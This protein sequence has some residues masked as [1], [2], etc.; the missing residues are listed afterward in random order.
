MILSYA[1]WAQQGNVGLP[2]LS[3]FD[4]NDYEY[5]KENEALVQDENGI[6]YIANNDGLLLFD[7]VN[8]T[9]MP[10]PNKSRVRS[11][12]LSEDG[13]IYL[14]GQGEFGFLKADSLFKMTY[15]SLSDSIQKEDQLPGDIWEIWPFENKILF[16]AGNQVLIYDG[17]TIKTFKSD[18]FFRKGFLI[19]DKMYIQEDGVGLYYWNGNTLVLTNSNP[20]FSQ[21]GVAFLYEEDDG[22][23]LIGM[24]RSG[25]YKGDLKNLEKVPTYLDNTSLQIKLNCGK[26]LKNGSL[27]LGTVNQGLIALDE[28][29]RLLYELNKKFGLDVLTIHDIVE[30]LAG[31][32]WLTSDNGLILLDVNSPLKKIDDRLGVFGAGFTS[33]KASNGKVLFG[34]SQAIFEQKGNHFEVINNTEGTAWY[35]NNIGTNTWIGTQ[36]GPVLYQYDELTRY[37]TPLGAWDFVAGPTEDIVLAG[38]YRGIHVFENKG[39]KWEP[40]NQIEGI[41]ES[42]RGL[43]KENDSVLW[44]S[45]PYKGVYR[46]QLTN[47]LT[48]AKSVKAFGKKDG[49]PSDLRIEVF[50]IKEQLLFTSENGVFEFD[51]ENERFRNCE[52]F[53]KIVGK[54]SSISIIQEDSHGYIWFVDKG[55]PAYIVDEQLKDPRIVKAPLLQ[56]KDE[57]IGSYEH[58]NDLG[59]QMIIGVQSGYVVF[60]YLVEQ[61]D[62]Y[63]YPVTI[64]RVEQTGSD[65]AIVFDGFGDRA[66]TDVFPYEK[67]GLKFHYSGAD[68]N[69]IGKMTYRYKLE[70]FDEGWSEW[71]KEY[72][73]EYTNLFEGSYIFQ[74][75]AKNIYGK[76]ILSNTWGFEILPPWYRTNWAYFTFLIAISVSLYGSVKMYTHYQVRDLKDLQVKSSR[77]VI[78]LKNEKLESEAQHNTKQLASMAFSLS[79]KENAIVSIKKELEEALDDPDKM[80]FKIK[81]IVSHIN[82]EIDVQEEWDVFERHFD[83][84]HNNFMTRLRSKHP[85]LSPIQ[86]KLSAYLRMNLSSKE[87]ADLMNVSV[88]GVEKNRYRLRKKLGLSQDDNLKAYIFQ[89]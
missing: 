47:D 58:F 2:Y 3:H 74:V 66:Q 80:G 63:D 28:N 13:T 30:D 79:Q 61:R 50:K 89:I 9:L 87:M 64:R 36:Y 40:K 25:L 15:V 49:L 82:Q 48:K 68:Y 8:W 27:L 44:M 86:N 73:K 84:V 22:A 31:Q 46:L 67:N 38:N 85:D 11:L 75:E 60:D 77:E 70:G 23:L 83:Q 69:S 20:I 29:G 72:S 53:E 37:N 14:G 81:K 78:R 45:Q 39:G 32:M 56:L 65:G 21:E 19:D 33:A 6:L 26:K 16:L 76:S 88:S 1:G 7:G 57:L 51:E 43:V 59:D 52:W 4:K 12:A 62:N 41:N 35:M 42:T 34:T 17:C 5:G 71:S 54:H 10:L 55:Q 24:T 18:S